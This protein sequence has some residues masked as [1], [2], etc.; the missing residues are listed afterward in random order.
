MKKEN[1]IK[2]EDRISELPEFIIDYILLGLDSS[3]ERVRVSVL[4]RRWRDLTNSFP[5][6]HFNFDEFVKGLYGTR[7][8]RV[9]RD[10][11]FKHVEHSVYRFCVWQNQKNVHTFK[12]CTLFQDDKEVAIINKCLELILQTGVKVLDIDIAGN[13]KNLQ[14]FCLPIGPSS[15]VSSLTSL[16]MSRNVLPLSLNGDDVANTAFKYLKVLHFNLVSLDPHVIEHL[17]V[18]CRLLE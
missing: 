11:F 15:S 8:H 10:L 5:Y 4:S 17:T 6:F 18:S 16:K 13:T 2:K 12:L 14:N 9:A 3:K 1:M 7:Y